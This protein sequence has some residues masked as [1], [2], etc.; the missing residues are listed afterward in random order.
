MKYFP[1]TCPGALCELRIK[2]QC[3]K[4]IIIISRSVV[5]GTNPDSL[6]GLRPIQHMHSPHTIQSLG[7]SYHRIPKQTCCYN[8]WGFKK[9]HFQS[10]L[11]GR[12]VNQRPIV[13]FYRLYFLAFQRIIII[14]NISRFPG[15]YVLLVE[16]KLKKIIVS[17]FSFKWG[18]H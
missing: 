6:H 13:R 9:L 5:L 4:L 10:T 7:E 18:K 15:L 2:H 12:G 1:Q 8:T 17:H 16:I 3:E 11:R 14:M